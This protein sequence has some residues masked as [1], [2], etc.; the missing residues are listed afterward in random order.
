MSP[1]PLFLAA[2]SLPK[3]INWTLLGPLI[4]LSLIGAAATLLDLARRPARLLLGGHR[5]RWVLVI[6][7]VFGL[8]WA[9]Y[10]LFGRLAEDDLVQPEGEVPHARA[11][12]PDSPARER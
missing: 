1:D 3:D 4:A 7:M 12:Y 11:H 10:L 2:Q 8:G 5:W 9:L 6:V